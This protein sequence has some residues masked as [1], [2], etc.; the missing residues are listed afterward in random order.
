MS[1]SSWNCCCCASPNHPLSKEQKRPSSTSPPSSPSPAD[2]I[3]KQPSP[4]LA[5]VPGITDAFQQLDPASQWVLLTELVNKCS[6]SQLTFLTNIIAPKL[7][8]DFLHDLPLELAHHIL[9]FIDDPRSLARAGQVSRFWHQLIETEDWVWRAQC[10]R[11]FGP[12]SCSSL[13]S[14]KSYIAPPTSYLYTTSPTSLD[15]VSS[16]LKS[17]SNSPSSLYS[18]QQR[19]PGSLSSQSSAQPSPS[20]LNTRDPLSPLSSSSSTGATASTSLSSAA[21]TNVLS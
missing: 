20:W 15:A 3:A 19:S 10:I 2:T 14:P 16:T 8:R 11:M 7:K 18:H 12:T 13:P 6:T 5:T 21:T 4:I 9:S 17:L 1:S